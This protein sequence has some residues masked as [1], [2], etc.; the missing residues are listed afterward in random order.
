YLILAL[1]ALPLTAQERYEISV[2]IDGYEEEFLSLANN[3]LDKQYLVDTAYRTDEGKYIFESDTNALPKGIYLVVLAPDNNYFQMLVGDDE[4][5]V[6]SLKTSLDKLNEVEVTGSEENRLFYDYLSFLGTQQQASQPLRQQLQDS[7]LSTAKR[8]ELLAKMDGYSQAVEKHQDA[9]IKEHPTSFVAAIIKTNRPF[10]PPPMDDITDETE[11]N[12]AQLHWLQD[13][14]LDPI[15]LKDD[16]LLRTPFLFNRLNYFVDKLF[17]QYPDT[18][19]MAIDRVLERMNPSS[20]MFK[21]YV[22]HFTNKSASSKIVGM[23]AVY[24]HM[25]D[26]YYAT[27]LASWSSPE[28]LKTMMENAEKARPLII[29]KQAPNMK[30]KRRDGTPVELYDLKANYTVLYFWQFA[31]PS[32]K[33]STP[34]MKEFYEKWKDRGVEIFSIC[35][36]Q[37]EIDKCWEYIDDNAI[38]DWLHATDRY[39]RFYKDYDI[40]STPTIFVLDENKEIV[41]KRIGAEQLDGLLEALEKEKSR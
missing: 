14:Y 3:L 34:V 7:T 35:T 27:G 28:Q 30:M 1:F 24:V 37:G 36:K 16:R 5:Q 15:N 13:H 38:G 2:E 25:V 33:K 18:V 23:D 29:G 9:V 19:S 8:E 39:L 26:K 31:C 40:R 20:E 17:Y 6:F 22:V 21:Y 4:D 11:R 41:S 32:C 10:P 12:T